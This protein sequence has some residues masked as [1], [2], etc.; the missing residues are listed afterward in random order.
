M[1]KSVINSLMGFSSMW[2]FYNLRVS[3]NISFLDSESEGEISKP[4]Y[5][6]S[7]G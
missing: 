5:Q 2:F 6:S 7:Q 3:F 4:D 1:G